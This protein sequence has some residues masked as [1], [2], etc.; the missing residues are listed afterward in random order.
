[1]QTGSREFFC[2]PRVLSHAHPDL[3]LPCSG[4]VALAVV[5]ENETLTKDLNTGL[6]DRSAN[7]VAFAVEALKLVEELINKS[8]SHSGKI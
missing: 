6:R 7:M 5:G 4:Y 8:A 1:M 3:R 2:C